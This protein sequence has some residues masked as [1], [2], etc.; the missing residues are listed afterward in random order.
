MKHAITILTVLLLTPLAVLRAG[1]ATPVVLG[2]AGDLAFEMSTFM[3]ETAHATR[4]CPPRDWHAQSG[5]MGVNAKWEA[6]H[7]LP[8][9]IEDQRIGGDYVAAGLAFDNKDEVRWG[10]KVLGWGFAH[11]DHDGEF[12]H[13]DC[14]HSASFFIEAAAHAL[15]LIEASPLRAEFSGQVQVL[16]PK[17]HAAAGWMVR[18]DVHAWVWNDPKPANN[19]FP[20]EL[21][22]LIRVACRAS[23]SRRAPVVDVLRF[24]L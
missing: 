14:Y 23:E 8:W 5:A 15:L 18:P 17:V 24:Q 21:P 1:D 13:P 2:V 6:D 7:S 22:V 12:K 11:M 3:R 4:K 10:L 19:G 9:F 16:K 20:L